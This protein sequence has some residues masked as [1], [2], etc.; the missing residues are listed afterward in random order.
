MK[1]FSSMKLC[2]RIFFYL[3]EETNDL[4]RILI[5]VKKKKMSGQKLLEK[6]KRILRNLFFVKQSDKKK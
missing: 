6:K 2:S 3:L 4:G 5:F 1:D